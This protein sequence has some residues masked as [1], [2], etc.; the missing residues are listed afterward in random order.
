MAQLLKIETNDLKLCFE[1]GTD[2]KKQ[3]APFKG[4][5]EWITYR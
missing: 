1:V 3:S 4:N 2:R 5:L